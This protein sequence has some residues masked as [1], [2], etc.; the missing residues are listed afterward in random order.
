M[1]RNACARERNKKH[2]N[3]VVI[4]VRMDCIRNTW[5]QT[6][7]VGLSG[8]SFF[9]YSFFYKIK[10]EVKFSCFSSR[11]FLWTK[12]MIN[13]H[14]SPHAYCTHFFVISYDDGTANVFRFQRASVSYVRQCSAN[15]QPTSGQAQSVKSVGRG[16]KNRTRTQNQR[17]V[18]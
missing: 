7:E 17:P 18:K 4:G 11:W 5:H 12:R 10:R 13:T 3:F 14:R 15:R 8:M 16:D 2:W 9:L 1:D 6:H